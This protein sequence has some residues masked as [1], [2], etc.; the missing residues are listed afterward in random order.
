MNRTL[1]PVYH[2]VHDT[3][4]WQKTFN[5]PHFT[6]H[7][8]MSQIGARIVLEAA[9]TPI[10]PYNL[11]DYKEALERN[12]EALE[13]YHKSLLLKGNVTLD[14]LA[15]Q[16]TQFSRN[17]EAFEKKK[18]E[19]RDTQDFAKLRI[20]NDQMMNMER[21]FI[22]PFGLPGRKLVRHVLFAPQ[23]HNIYGSSTFP[24]IT[25]ALFDIEKTNDW[26]LVK[27]QVSIAITCVREAGK[28]LAAMD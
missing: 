15:S 23:M 22:W 19:A 1:Y 26:K 27:E 3:F 25:D 20:L 10:L 2:T 5:D 28:I 18:A 12:F 21:A 6:T 11:M 24:G 8:S 16:I 14:H 7:L 13:K 4:Y 17:A 9:D